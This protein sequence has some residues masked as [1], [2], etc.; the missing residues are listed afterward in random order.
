MYNNPKT[1]AVDATCMLMQVNSILGG[2]ISGSSDA[3]VV[4]QA[5]SRPS[6]P[7][8]GQIDLN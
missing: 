5:P 1:E 3:P 8:N 4:G 6:N 7:L 2:E